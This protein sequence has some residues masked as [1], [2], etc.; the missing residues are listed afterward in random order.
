LYRIFGKKK[1][2]T[3]T[4]EHK[5]PFWEKSGASIIMENFHMEEWAIMPLR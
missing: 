1:G 2:L 5:I 4:T 3:L